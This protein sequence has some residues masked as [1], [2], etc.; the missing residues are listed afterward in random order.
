L[1]KNYQ[2]AKEQSYKNALSSISNS[3]AVLVVRKESHDI[4]GCTISSTFSVTV[5]PTQII[6][7]VLKENTVTANLLQHNSN[8]TINYLSDNQEYVARNYALPSPQK[9]SLAVDF[10]EQI[11]GWA[12][13]KAPLTFRCKIADS[14]RL[15][16]NIVFFAKVEKYIVSGR[17]NSMY[18]NR[19]YFKF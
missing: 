11:D 7:F 16:N 13:S 17:P 3:V 4:H 2:T 8:F 9:S 12:V 15:D 19:N 10:N 18:R 1:I 14:K 6:G 5:E